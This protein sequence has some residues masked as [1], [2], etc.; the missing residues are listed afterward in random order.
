MGDSLEYGRYFF[1]TLYI[2]VFRERM[3]GSIEDV[4]MSLI[5]T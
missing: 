1:R 5:Y 2:D 4:S 3:R